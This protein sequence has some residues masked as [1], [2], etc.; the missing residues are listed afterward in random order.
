MKKFFMILAPEG[1]LLG[2]GGS[3]TTTT[4]TQSTS[5]SGDPGTGTPPNGVPATPPAGGEPFKW[6]ENW[7][8]GLAELANDPS[9]API[10]DIPSL[11]KSFINAQ[12]MIGKDKIIVPDKHATKEDWLNNVFK[13]LGLPEAEDKY[14]FKA[15]EGSDPN[16]I[17][18]FKKFALSEGILPSQAEGLFNFYS[19]HVKEI[20]EAEDNNHKQM[21]ETAVADLKKEFGTAYEKKLGVASTLFNS[22]ADEKTKT[23]FKETGLGNNPEVIK[24]FAKLAERLGEDSFVPAEMKGNMGLTPGDAQIKINEIMGNKT[25]PYWDSQ[26]PNHANA[27]KEMGVLFAMTTGQEK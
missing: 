5:Q 27:V 21:F 11:A 19:S 26:H 18:K 17:S 22:V 14:E 10:N 24:I 16:F 20:M 23:F 12:K 1:D 2:G 4:N 25:H 8:Q 9:L 3:Q 6:P 15:P 13:K 7:K